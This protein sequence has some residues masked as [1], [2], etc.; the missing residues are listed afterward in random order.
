MA[1]NDRVGACGNGGHQLAY[2]NDS[3]L[4]SWMHTLKEEVGVEYSRSHRLRYSVA[5]CPSSVSP[6]QVA[7]SSREWRASNVGTKRPRMSCRLGASTWKS[8]CGKLQSGT[9]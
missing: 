2:G 1:R 9:S 7:G 6:D 3:D 4:A 5:L 8:C